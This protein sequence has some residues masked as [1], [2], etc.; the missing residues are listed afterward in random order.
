MST[1]W[2]SKYAS[3]AKLLR[4][5][6]IR[7]LLRL[8]ERP[9]TISFAGGLPA[10]EL[11]PLAECREAC[12]RVLAEQGAA[13]LQY[14][15]TEGYVPLREMIVR[16]MA[17]YGVRSEVGNVLITSGSQQAL[18]LVAK[19]LLSPGDGVVV[20]EPTYLGGLQA[21]RSYE[22]R[23]VSVPVDD[24]GIRVDLLEEVLRTQRI[25]LLYLLPNFQNPSGVSM[26][27]L[28]RQRVVEL[29][30]RYDVLILEDD[31]YGQ[32]RYEG[33]HR[34][35]LIVLDDERA[36]GGLPSERGE[37]RVV[38][39]ST[40]SKLV[41]PGFRVGWVTGPASVI[42]SLVLMKQG[43]D[44]HTSTFSQMVAFETCHGGFL[45]A[46]VRKLRAVY[47]ERRDAMFQALSEFMPE[48]VR[49]TRPEGGLFLWLT[50]PSDLDA[51]DLLKRSLER[52]VAFVPGAAFHATG[53]GR[54]T[55]RVNFSYCTPERIAQGVRELAKAVEEC[56]AAL[57]GTRT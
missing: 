55:L 41:A 27:E 51:R 46:H 33:E 45:D 40:L 17:R 30:A 44:L 1:L 16:H 15:T 24:D 53:G 54:N 9:E 19:L 49:W 35:P 6:E 43:A 11:F 57:G 5:S 38:Y 23:F 32:L 47:A 10:P 37:A 13:A 42:Q 50:L 21:F 22:P 48:G 36:R 34:T 12:K 2:N 26:S 20:E 25:K 4:A 52:H 18:D 56:L 31:P 7:E 8:T 3:R 29:A 28:R 39:T 14:S